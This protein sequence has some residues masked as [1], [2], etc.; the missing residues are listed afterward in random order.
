MFQFKIKISLKYSLLTEKFRMC[1]DVD[2]WA[3]SS[4]A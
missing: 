3:V 1:I 2:F 4:Q